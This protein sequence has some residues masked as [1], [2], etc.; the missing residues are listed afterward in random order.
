MIKYKLNITAIFKYKLGKLFIVLNII[1]LISGCSNKINER[2]YNFENDENHISFIIEDYLFGKDD[3]YIRNYVNNE[4]AT[5]E[6][7]IDSLAETYSVVNSIELIDENQYKVS[8]DN[9]YILYIKI[10]IKNGILD[11]IVVKSN[12]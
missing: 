2:E 1:W 7:I 12:K 3:D 5:N 10:S 8:V 9:I 11:K 4:F 6:F